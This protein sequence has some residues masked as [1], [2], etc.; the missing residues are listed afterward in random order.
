MT[1]NQNIKVEKSTQFCTEFNDI[2]KDAIE[3]GMMN[4]IEPSERI[5]KHEQELASRAQAQIEQ[6]AAELAVLRQLDPATDGTRA[7]GVRVRIEN[8]YTGSSKWSSGHCTGWKLVIGDY[9]DTKWLKIGNGRELGLDAK[10][11]AK[12]LEKIREIVGVAQVQRSVEQAK[13][14]TEARYR[15]F[16]AAPISKEFVK[17]LTQQSWLSEY[18]TPEGFRVEENGK[19]TY[20]GETFTVSQW[21][22][23]I[24]LRVEQAEAMKALKASFASE[25]RFAPGTK[26]SEM[27]LV[28]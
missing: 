13:A 1:T 3:A 20:K 2:N 19:L 15:T 5:V 16:I 18:S 11:K 28:S 25:V 6:A 26:P 21:S 10:Q 22:K 9:G 27:K 12:A 8:M 23:V 17:Q 14:A 4:G 24:A 7:L